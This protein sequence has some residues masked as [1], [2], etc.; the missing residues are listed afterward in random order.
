MIVQI[1]SLPS[2]RVRWGL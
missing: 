1:K 2:T